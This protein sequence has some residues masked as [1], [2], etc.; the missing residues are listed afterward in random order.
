MKNDTTSVTHFSIVLLV[1]A[2]ILFC[3]Q[4]VAAQSIFPSS[5]REIVRES[6]YNYLIIKREG[7]LV[8]FRRIEN[9]AAVSAIDMSNPTRQVIS[10][11]A[12]LFSAALIEP[13]PAHVLN[14]GLG[15][16]AINRLIEPAFSGSMI[17]TVEID[18][19]I[20]DA[21]KTYTAFRESASNKVVIGDGRRFLQRENTKWDWIVLDAFVRNSQVPPHLTTVEFYR[22]VQNHLQDNGVFV[23]NLHEGSALFQ[24]NV[25]TMTAAF[26]Q[27]AFYSVPRSGSVIGMG[28]NF[29]NPPLLQVIANSNLKALPTLTSAGVDFAT[30]KSGWEPAEKFTIGRDINLL[31]DDFA[32][33]EFLD[34]QPAR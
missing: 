10:Y 24:S 12:A 7:S 21:A 19:M 23:V 2:S 1:A 15:A 18:S 5:D 30:L 22:A 31:T 25:K 8:T 34:V 33:V 17:V 20:V 6:L 27:T 13:H 16:G 26:A 4:F 32:P 3:S 14:I 11:T 9:G 28:V 29:R